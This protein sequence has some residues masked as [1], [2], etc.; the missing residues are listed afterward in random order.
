M[1]T[2]ACSRSFALLQVRG[3]RLRTGSHSRS[4]GGSRTPSRFEA[5][6]TSEVDRNERQSS[7]LVRF[8][9]SIEPVQGGRVHIE[10]INAPFTF[11]DFGASIRYAIERADSNARER[12]LCAAADAGRG[13]APSVGQRQGQ[14]CREERAET[15]SQIWQCKAHRASP[16]KRIKYDPASHAGLPS[17]RNLGLQFARRHSRR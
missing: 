10:K 3:A 6:A 7:R 4:P 15:N 14:P 2:S 13:P 1:V 9:A 17:T 16:P 5:D 12:D 11:G 8:A